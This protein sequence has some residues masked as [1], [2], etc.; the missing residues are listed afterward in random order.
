MFTLLAIIA[1]L[2]GIT[3]WVWIL[4]MVFTENVPYAVAIFFI[5][6]LAVVYGW[7]HW[8]EAKAPTVLYVVGVVGYIVLRCVS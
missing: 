5:S 3:G 1:I 6:P 8:D 7:L 4:M 2:M